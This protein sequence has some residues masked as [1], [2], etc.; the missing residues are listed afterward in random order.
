[1]TYKNLGEAQDEEERKE[2]EQDQLAISICQAMLNTAL[3]VAR[4]R[5]FVR[6]ESGRDDGREYTIC[7]TNIED[8]IAALYPLHSFSRSIYVSLWEQRSTG[9][10]M[11]EAYQGKTNKQFSH[12][13]LENLKKYS[14][15]HL[16]N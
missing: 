12:F 11:L 14:S 3:P 16:A 4:F 7:S 2:F 6:I 15:A 9:A 10:D 13:F 1:M 8:V 5:C